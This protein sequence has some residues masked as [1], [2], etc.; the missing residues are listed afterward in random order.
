MLKDEIKKGVKIVGLFDLIS[1]GADPLDGSW[2]VTKNLMSS[3]VITFYGNNFGKKPVRV[4]PYKRGENSS[5]PMTGVEVISGEFT[6]CIMGIYKQGGVVSV[7]H[8]DTEVDGN[9]LLLQKDAWAAQKGTSGFQLYNEHSTKGELPKFFNGS[10]GT[11]STST[12]CSTSPQTRRPRTPSRPAYLTLPAVSPATR[13]RS[14]RAKSATTGTM[15]MSEAAKSE[16]Q[17]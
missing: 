14:M 4:L 11:A 6:G 2:T 17:C 3:N 15:A 12:R 13:W 10:T 7:N 16:F 1:K 9:G 5:T 8:V